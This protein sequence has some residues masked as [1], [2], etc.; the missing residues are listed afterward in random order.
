MKMNKTDE[1]AAVRVERTH[2]HRYTRASVAYEN[3]CGDVGRVDS[4]I[5]QKP[6]SYLFFHAR[7]SSL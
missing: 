4:R 6:K 5:K 7:H 1:L 3:G 2:T